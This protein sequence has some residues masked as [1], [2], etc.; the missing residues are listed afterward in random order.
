[1]A[2]KDTSNTFSDVAVTSRLEKVNSFLKELDS[3]ID[4][5]KLGNH[6]VVKLDNRYFT[7]S[8]V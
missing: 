3:I 1:M 6:N 4:F 7:L 2:F 8:V 5:N